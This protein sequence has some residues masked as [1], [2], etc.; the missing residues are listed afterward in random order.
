MELKESLKQLPEQPGIYFMKNSLGTV[1]YVG[2][3]KSLKS[4]VSQYFQKKRDNSP[5]VN[6]MIE[7]I[8]SIEYT[9][10]DTELEAFLLECRTIKELQPKYNRQLKNYKGYTY[11]KISINDEYPKLS[12]VTQQKKDRSLY[13]GP[14]T[15][16]GSVDNTIQFI[17]DY[18]PIR[19]CSRG[20]LARNSSGCLNFHLGTC[21]GPCRGSDKQEEYRK[22]INNIVQFL[23]GNDN[24]PVKTLNAKMKS[25]AN[26]LEFEKAAQYR[27]QIRGIRH[28]LN[29]QR[30]I[31]VSRYG[32]NILAAE[33][34]DEGSIKLFLIKGN[35]LL[36]SE[37]IRI[38][39]YTNVSLEEKLR[40]LVNAYFRA[41]KKQEKGGLSQEEIDEAQIIYSYLKNKSNEIR[42]INIPSSRIDKINYR[43]I[44]EMLLQK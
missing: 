27:D 35:K 24:A 18:Y 15:S 39:E 28:V 17:K 30:I 8:Y 29:K 43:K 32:R 22:Q 37:L 34:F 40:S 6:E 20:A 14:F 23:E 5:K 3:A 12:K 44:I 41:C 42:S 11:I 38:L 1:I 21:L 4:R 10:T 31:K 26:N 36:Y 7:H 25:A 2:K 33:R 19:K 9:T 13:F 16:E